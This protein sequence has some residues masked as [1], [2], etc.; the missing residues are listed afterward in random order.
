MRCRSLALI[1]LCAGCRSSGIPWRSVEAEL[2]EKGRVTVTFKA[3][4]TGVEAQV[5]AEAPA[6]LHFDREGTVP[7]AAALEVPQP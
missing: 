2:E 3:S 4:L 6:K 5:T 7:A 1:L